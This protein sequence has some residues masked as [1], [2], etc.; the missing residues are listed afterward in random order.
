MHFAHPWLLLLLAGPLLVGLWQRRHPG[1][2]VVLPFDHAAVAPGHRL[3]RWVDAAAWLPL[4]AAAGGI[5]LLARPQRQFVG[6]T[7]RQ[8]RTVQILVDVSGSMMSRYGAGTRFD[9]AMAA[10]DG[11]VRA[12]KGDAFAFSV[13]GSDVIDWMPPTKDA[14]AIRYAAPF[15]NPAVIPRAMSMTYIGYAVRQTMGRLAAQSGDRM[16][17]LITDGQSDD[18]G[19]RA[20]A[21]LAA[22]LRREHITLFSIFVGDDES[23][24]DIATLARRTGGAIFRPESPTALADAFRRIDAMAP[25]MLKPV[26]RISIDWPVPAAVAVLAALGLHTLCGFKLRYTPW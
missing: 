25:A 4:A 23:T 11:F 7:E 15:V 24:E 10:V 5:V 2:A 3:G 21:A 16:I 1:T 14:T 17:V 6:A 13:F 22:D 26:D 18:L 9:A 8:L 20:T 12:S 19:P